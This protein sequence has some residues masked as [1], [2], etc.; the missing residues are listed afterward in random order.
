MASLEL[1]R[2]DNGNSA[3]LPFQKL[4]HG[5][6]GCWWMMAAPASSHKYLMGSAL[7]RGMLLKPVSFCGS[8]CGH[9]SDVASLVC[10]KPSQSSCWQRS[11]FRVGKKKPKI[12]IIIK[13]L[14]KGG[15]N[16]ENKVKSGVVEP[17]GAAC[18]RLSNTPPIDQ[19]FTITYSHTGS[20]K[21]GE[22][23][24]GKGKSQ[25]NRMHWLKS[26]PWQQF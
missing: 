10:K 17:W 26:N 15:K 16:K 13:N 24:R 25:S 5:E 22:K 20:S 11:F 3:H 1:F 23:G 2:D 21:S 7:E 6:K 19:T 18:E 14:E 4:N 9:T 8:K 12:K